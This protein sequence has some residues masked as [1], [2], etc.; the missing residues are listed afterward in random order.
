M[1]NTNMFSSVFEGSRRGFDSGLREYMLRVYTLMASALVLSS[2]TGFAF[3]N[4]PALTSLIY[5]V[6]PNGMIQGMSMLGLLVAF[7]PMMI[8]FSLFA[9]IGTMNVQTAQALFWTYAAIMGVS[10]SSLGLTYTSASITKALLITAST[11]GAISIYGYTTKKDLSAIGSIALMG[12]FGLIIAS[13]VNIFMMSPAIDFAVSV[14]GVVIFT[15]ITAYDTQRIKAMY[16]TSGGGEYGQKVAIIGAL[17]LYL[18]FVN[19]FI[20]ILRFMGTRRD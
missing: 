17:T 1:A 8:G 5:N 20:Y 15:A 19:L 13:I 9:G 11:F 10:L 3:M 4:V 18:D 7:A 6:A 2:I 16:Y 12:V 14:L